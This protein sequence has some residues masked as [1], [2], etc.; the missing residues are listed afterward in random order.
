ML[1]DTH[2]HLTMPEYRDIEQVLD[3][4]R[5]AGLEFIIDVGFDIDSSEKSTHLS[6]NS[7]FIYSAV[8]IH[9]HDAKSFHEDTFRKL[10]ELVEMPR[11][12]AIG[13]IGLDYHYSLS[14]QEEQKRVF[15]KL[16]WLAR[17]KKLPIIIHGRESYSDIKDIIIREG[18]SNIE[19]VFHSFAGDKDILKWALDSGFYISVSGMVTFKKAQN[20]VDTVK[21]VPMDRLL[22]ETDCP[23][24]T[25]DPHR[26]TRNEPAYVKLVAE[27]VA[28]IK[29]MTLDEVGEATTKNA[30]RLFKLDKK[31]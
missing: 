30:K 23:Y 7:N 16:L 11:V 24:L 17:E 6:K 22:I 19:G 10:Q 13:E 21:A 29:G 8:G 4:A 2:A 18:H 27:A 5:S 31:T 20:I 1:A 26:G 28:S 15:S 3:R 9:P 25:P 12:V 14:S